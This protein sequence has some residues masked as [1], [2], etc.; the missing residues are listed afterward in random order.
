MYNFTTCQLINIKLQ[1]SQIPSLK[2][3][4]LFG[5]QARGN[6]HPNSDYDFAVL[7]Q[8]S[9]RPTGFEY[10][11]IYEQLAD[12][13]NILSDEIDVVDLNYCSDLTAHNIAR[14]GQVLYEA[15]EGLFDSFR[16][17]ALMSNAELKQLRQELRQD[18]ND[19]LTKSSL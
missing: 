7:Y 9:Y 18:I 19:F 13:F 4:I 3:L 5:S 11:Q 8:E 12:I 17:Q 1:L 10:F 2:M 15:Q 16:Q 14:D 6:T